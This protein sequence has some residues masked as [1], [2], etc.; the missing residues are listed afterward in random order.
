MALFPPIV[1]SSMPAFIYTEGVRVYFSLSSY[2]TQADIKHVQVTVR[3]QTTN[4]SALNKS[5]YANA[6]KVTDLLLDEDKA[7]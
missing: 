3:Y 1:A 7:T 2:N 6:I 4:Q 5:M